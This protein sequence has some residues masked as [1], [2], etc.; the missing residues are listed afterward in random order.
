MHKNF[1]IGNFYFQLIYPE[2]IELPEH[3][4]LFEAGNE[5]TVVDYT[6]Q[7]ILS[8]TFPKPKGKCLAKRPDLMV[9]ENPENRE[10]RYIGI[11]GSDSYYGCYDEISNETACIFLNPKTI[12]HLSFDPVFSSLFA[13]ERRMARQNA[14]ILHCA[15][16]QYHHSAILFSGPSGIGKTTQANLWKKFLNCPTINGDRALLRSIKGQWYAD[17]WPVCGTS[18]ICSKK[19]LPI[20]AIVLLSKGKENIIKYPDTAETFKALYAQLT[21]NG[22]HRDMVLHSI[23]LMENLMYTMP[24]FHL[25]CNISKQAVDVLEEA[26]QPVNCV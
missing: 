14:L 12:E 17:G 21:I 8:D 9:Y 3:F 6:Y 16:V 11:K 23:G 26:L 15:Y 20:S 1:L 13:F 19:L 18:D 4:L 25:Q 2:Q 24:V 7:M 22:W 5:M 10:L